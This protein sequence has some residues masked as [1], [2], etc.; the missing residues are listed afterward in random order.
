[1]HVVNVRRQKQGESRESTTTAC[2]KKVSGLA[3]NMRGAQHETGKCCHE[4]VRTTQDIQDKQAI[5][6]P[7]SAS[8]DGSRQTSF[9]QMRGTLARQAQ[10]REA[11]T[12]GKKVYNAQ[13]DETQQCRH[14]HPNQSKNDSTE[15]PAIPQ[16]IRLHG[17][18][19]E[20][21]ERRGR[22][23]T[24]K[25]TRALLRIM[26]A[27]GDTQRKTHEEGARAVQRRQRREAVGVRLGHQV[28]EEGVQVR[29]GRVHGHLTNRK[30][31]TKNRQRDARRQTREV[32]KGAHQTSEV[33][34]DSNQAF[35]QEISRELNDSTNASD[36]ALL[37]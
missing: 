27:R 14:V 2:L 24:Q 13:G 33:G 9:S 7:T 26:R 30:P 25:G 4:K 6:R 1:M 12:P 10:K 22:G 23:H 28:L 19:E 32:K 21:R 16:N 17:E 37:L 31:D 3:Y 8:R 20:E 29:E 34:G 36:V 35:R 11:E 5:P 15:C 18:E